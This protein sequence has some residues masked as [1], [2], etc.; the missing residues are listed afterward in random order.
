LLTCGCTSAVRRDDV[1]DHRGEVV[2]FSHTAS[3]FLHKDAPGMVSP[4]HGYS[5]NRRLRVIMTSAQPSPPTKLKLATE[6]CTLRVSLAR[7]RAVSYRT[8]KGFEFDPPP[9]MSPHGALAT[10]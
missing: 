8:Q 10:K 5:S 7:M 3:T 9:Q 1:S 4:A 6:I 2:D